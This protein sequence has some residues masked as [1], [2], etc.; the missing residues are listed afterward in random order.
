MRERSGVEALGG[1]QRLVPALSAPIRT[2]VVVHILLLLLLLLLPLLLLPP[3][4]PVLL[5]G[6]LTNRETFTN[7]CNLAEEDD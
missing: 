2:P 1:V 6:L 4:A 3:W 5:R 7:I